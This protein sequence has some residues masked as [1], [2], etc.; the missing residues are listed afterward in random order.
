MVGADAVAL[1]L[2]LWAALLLKFDRL[3]FSLADH[4]DLFLVGA[5]AAIL[6]FSILGLYRAII[7]F[8]GPQAMVV[9]VVGIVLSAA[10]LALYDRMHDQSHIPLSAL[11]IYA[12]LA[13]LYLAASRFHRALHV[14]LRP[15][16]SRRSHA[17][18]DLRRR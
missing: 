14:L 10:T 15:Q 12:A 9:V 6:I 18:R 7:R 11:A 2:A 3:S 5:G 17:R 4:W 16:R 8:I 13:L 1:P